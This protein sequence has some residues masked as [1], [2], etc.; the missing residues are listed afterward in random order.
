MKFI[1]FRPFFPILFLLFLPGC[2]S[3]SLHP[4]PIDSNSVESCQIFYS[5]LEDQVKEAGV[6]EA[7]NFIIPGFP[8]LRTN[9]FLTALKDKIK[10]EKEREQWLRWMKAMDLRAREKEISNL[11][12][13]RV[14][15]LQALETAQPNRKEVYAE[16]ES[17][18]E[19]LFIHDKG[20]AGLSTTLDS[21]MEVPDEY[22]FLRRA[23]GL[24]PLMAVPV[25]VASRRAEAKTRSWFRMNLDELPL[26]GRLKTY[27]PLENLTLREEEVRT[28]LEDSKKNVLEV[29]LPEE[30]QGKRLAWSFAPVFIQDVAAPYDQIGEVVW[31]KNDLN[32]DP[33]R[34]TVYYYFSH[35]YLKEKPILQINYVIWY[36]DRTGESPPWI[37]K[38]R[39]DGITYRVSLDPQGKVFMAD[40]M[41]NCGCYH[42]FAPVKERVE[43]I[44]SKPFK[45][46]PFV[47]QWLPTSPAGNRLGIRVSSGW[48]R[49][50]RLLGVL[51]PHD[52]IL[53]K[54]APYDDLKALPNERGR[55]E[56]IFDSK[57]IVKGSERAE[58]FILFSMGIPKIGSMREQG[59]H[60]I[61]L[62]RRTHFDD[63]H[64]FDHHF[65]FKEAE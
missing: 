32:I 3:I 8:Y 20:E 5:R 47:P 43:R 14:L 9:R 26:P 33:E 17:C 37:E 24:Y 34:P 19:K 35:A 6:R 50:E 46:D 36:S 58:R 42:L 51:E 10:D 27:A 15:S 65:V 11:P 39:M 16:V 41:S 21:R 38:G 28:L 64:L 59:H 57:G 31:K 7:S 22:S 49:V 25:A 44:V 52:P 40:V 18:S 55:T 4:G 23:V 2:V 60:S 30:E 62:I 63:P 54:L 53:Y 61:E 13:D 29:P 1:R 12:D 48:H 56:S 45:P